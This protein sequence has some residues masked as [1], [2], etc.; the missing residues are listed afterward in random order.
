VPRKCPPRTEIAELADRQFGYVKR[1]H[2]LALGAGPEWI[3]SQMTRGWLIRVHSGVYAVGHVPRHVHA[4]SFAAVLACGEGAV[5]SHASAAALWGAGGWPRT[6]EVSSPRQ[7]RRPR[8]RAHLSRTLGGRDTRTHQGIPVTSPVRTVLD[9][10]QRLAD[11]QL[12]RL[13]NDLRIAGHLR[14]GA[15]AELCRRSRR[16]ERLLGGENARDP[17]RPT[18]SWLEDRFRR[19]TAR[20]GLPM[21]QTS[22]TLAHNG[23]EVDALYPEQRLIVE[24]DSWSFHSSRA[25]FERDR[26]K[27]ADALAHGYRTLRVTDER[28]SRDG[29]QEAA[30]I[31]RI[32]RIGDPTRD[33]PRQ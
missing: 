21:P 29:A 14:S 7:C 15:F 4:R 24:V 20:H 1:T 23:R 2:L 18:R 6:P 8:I 25:S 19:F 17:E 28:L 13:V 11:P 3:R 31:D 27:D 5:L 26:A 22:A 33:P 9:L 32:L 16:V 30:R 10:Q 12:V